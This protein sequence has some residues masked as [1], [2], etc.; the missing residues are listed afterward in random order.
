MKCENGKTWRSPFLHGLVMGLALSLA[1]LGT[2]RAQTLPDDP[3]FARQWWLLN[4]G[5]AIEGELGLF[6]ADIRALAAWATHEGTSSVVVA[7]VGSGVDPHPEYADRLLEGVATI[8]DPFDS[9]DTLRFGTLA[10][11]IIGATKGN[12]TGIAGIVH[13]VMLL[14][15]RVVDG[16]TVTRSS[17]ARGIEWAVDQQADVI[18]VLVQFPSGSDE[19]LA[20]VNHATD[21]DVVLVAPVGNDS[22]SQVGF[23][24]AY[25]ACLA[26]SATN[27]LDELAAFSNFGSA[28]DLAAPGADIYS[29][30][31]GGTYG[32]E[33]SRTSMAAS[34]VAGV[35]ALIRSFAPQLAAWEIKDIL[36]ASADDLGDPGT[37]D[38]FGAGRVNAMS[39]L[40][41]APPPPI[42]IEHPVPFPSSGTPGTPTII[43][44]DIQNGDEVAAREGA[45]LFW[46][47]E[48]GS[49]FTAAPIKWVTG[50]RYEVI[51]PAAPC[52][53]SL[54]FYLRAVSEQGSIVLDPAEAPDT[55][56]PFTAISELAVFDDDFE[57]DRGW[58]TTIEGGEETHGPWVR[59]EPS[60]GIGIPGFDYSTDDGRKCFVTGRTV[61]NLPNKS[62]VDGG[63]VRLTSPSIAIASP[64]AVVSYARW[65]LTSESNGTDTLLVECSRD[66]G[67]TW[68]TVETVSSSQP[69]WLN[70]EFRLS[71]FPKLIGDRFRLRFSVV[72][73][74]DNDS[75][76]EA[77][78]DE[79]HVRAI[80]CHST[81]G[82]FDG[83]GSLEL[84]DFVQLTLCMGG[85]A[86]EPGG[87]WCDLMDMNHDTGVDLRDAG[88][89]MNQLDR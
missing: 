35:A 85:S 45:Q 88:A 86:D 9:T 34:V 81:Q 53:A 36:A 72:D 63:P 22:S 11:G 32:T 17:V 66:D 37:D 57:M 24:A 28:V 21:H 48:G 43:P 51:L 67:T 78:I 79:V 3:D 47:A 82:D 70:R 59:V 2:I 42:R 8:G 87:P 38:R 60:T 44:I 80:L 58:T 4:T 15:V 7:I 54:D 65:F 61:S 27:N 31:P 68:A 19:L 76:T 40:T 83:N 29:T 13:N 16:S 71:D 33:A 75:L 18:V 6:D 77:A 26:V 64:D 50:S 30:L 84:S 52:E 56:Y 10:A 46:R 62:D 49:S 69:A 23:P 41:M 89:F 14:P 74:I 1:N 20:A 25:E 55:T 12:A 73:P 39:A 5:Q